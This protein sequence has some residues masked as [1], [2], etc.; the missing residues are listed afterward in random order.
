MP[1]LQSAPTTPAPGTSVPDA[2]FNARNTNSSSISREQAIRN[3][4][5]ADAARKAATSTARDSIQSL[6][7]DVKTINGLPTV[8][9]IDGVGVNTDRLTP[10]SVPGGG[11]LL[12][13]PNESVHPFD[14]ELWPNS[15]FCNAGETY[16]PLSGWL[17]LGVDV[18]YGENETVVSIEPRLAGI[19]LPPLF[20][21]YRSPDYEPPESESEGDRQERENNPPSSPIVPILVNGKKTN[22]ECIYTLNK[23]PETG[24][25][26]YMFG[27]VSA[28]GDRIYCGGLIFYITHP[29]EL[30]YGTP[31]NLVGGT[32]LY[33][34]HKLRSF[35]F[36]GSIDSLEVLSLSDFPDADN[37][38]F[39]R[40]LAAWNQQNCLSGS[41]RRI[42]PPPPSPPPPKDPPMAC[43][44]KREIDALG[45]AINSL[46]NVVEALATT[47]EEMKE[48]FDEIKEDVDLAM[49]ILGKDDF[50]IVVPDHLGKVSGDG[51]VLLSIPEMHAYGYRQLSAMLGATADMKIK[52]KDVN[53]SEEGDQGVELKFPNL[54]EAITNLIGLCITSQSIETATL[55][56]SMRGLIQAGQAFTSAAVAA[57]QTSA[58]LETLGFGI[59]KNKMELP[60]S[61]RPGKTEPSELLQTTL[62]NVEY[63]ES[64]GDT[65]Q[66][67]LMTY[68]KASAIVR[69]SLTQ[70]I[71]TPASYAEMV[72]NA[73][74]K[75][76]ET[77]STSDFDQ[78]LEE[79]ERG[80]STT[81]NQTETPYGR[82]YEERPRIVKK[83]QGDANGANT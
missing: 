15:P 8:Q 77:G 6:A 55:N 74:S 7:E 17:D 49:T 53:L 33:V 30:Y 54:A 48:D 80:F 64:A 32:S 38:Y 82:P 4:R 39:H 50:P 43:P 79:V 45:R 1:F 63:W 35:S 78:Y 41:P 12:I 24:I 23:D 67:H 18:Y 28:S 21:G 37:R 42:S 11:Q 13:S 26:T 46:G 76:T 16:D 20:I 44:C 9:P 22:E 51:E 3:K 25:G 2:P 72:K 19:G 61:Y 52:V 29:S 60:L 70:N 59:E 81:S 34:L 27:P 65:L 68:D 36:Q 71:E 69:A 47:V 66:S 58:I 56:S 73:A 62:V 5:L 57:E 14:C 83:N 10:V 40:F 31:T 75:L